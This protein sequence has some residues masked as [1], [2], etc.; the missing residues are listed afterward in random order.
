MNFAANLRVEWIIFLPFIKYVQTLTRN[1]VQLLS[2]ELDFLQPLFLVLLKTT[3]IDQVHHGSHRSAYKLWPISEHVSLFYF[4]PRD[5]NFCQLVQL[6]KLYTVKLTRAKLPANA[7]NFTCSSQV[8]RSHTQF[9]CV[10]CSLLVKTD[11]FTNVNAAST[12]R[13][14][15]VT[16]LQ[17]RVNLPEYNGYFTYNFSFG[18]N[19]KLLAFAIKNTCNLQAETQES[20]VK[21][22]AQSQAKR[23]ANAHKNTC[24]CRQSAITPRV[25]SPAN[26]R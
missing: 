24:N 8:K 7:G 22:P 6:N 12:S 4:F 10:T 19:A 15:H 1:V 23:P 25:N 14:I 9:T 11:K 18:T 26:W 2:C 16:F 20:Q 17:P 3:T 5:N 21:V 13:R